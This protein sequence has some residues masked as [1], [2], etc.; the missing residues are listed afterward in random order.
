[1][2]SPPNGG[3]RCTLGRKNLQ[4][5]IKYSLYL[6]NGTRLAVSMKDELEI[7]YAMLTATLPMT[8]SNA[9]HDKSALVCIFVFLYN[10]EQLKCTG[11]LCQV[12]ACG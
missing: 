8:F 5:S 7:I 6:E 11:R 10:F 9:N 12:L 3:A 2:V 1:M 4:L